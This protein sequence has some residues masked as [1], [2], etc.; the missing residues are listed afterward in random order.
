VDTTGRSELA[1]ES[2]VS[3][4]GQFLSF[5]KRAGAGRGPKSDGHNPQ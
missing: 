5:R 1:F 2:W 3:G 4:V